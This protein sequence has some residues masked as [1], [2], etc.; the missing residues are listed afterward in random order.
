MPRLS[1]STAEFLSMWVIMMAG[2]T[3]FSL[4]TAG[5]LQL[6]FRPVLAGWLFNDDGTVTF[7]FLGGVQVTYHNPAK[8]DSWRLR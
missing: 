1:G 8:T 3:P 5:K 6:I 2:K 7:T 4:D